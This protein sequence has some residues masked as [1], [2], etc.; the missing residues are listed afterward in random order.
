MSYFNQITSTFAGAN[1]SA[2]GTLETNELSPVF[3]GDFA[4]GINTQLWNYF[5]TFTVTAPAVAPLIGD[6]YTNTNSTFTVIYISGTT[7][8]MQGTGT[9]AASGNLVRVTGI[10]STPIVYSAFTSSA[11]VSVGAGALVDTDTGR[12]RLQSGTSATGF[13]YITSRK[14]LRHRAGQG[15]TARFTPLFTTGVANSTQLWGVGGI[16]S[17]APYDGFYFG[18]NGISYGIVHYIGATPTWYS[19]SVDWNGDKVNGTAGTSFTLDPTKGSAVMI[20]YP[21]LG[22]G[23]VLFFIQNPTDSTWVLVH[24]IRYANTTTTPE[25]TNPS[26]QF[27]CYNANSGAVANKIMY[28]GSVGMFISGVVSL[29]S[30][31]KYAADSTKTTVTTEVC[32]LS[33]RNCSTFNGVINRG[34]IRL[35]S[36]SIG[37]GS[38]TNNNT[39]T[40]RIKIGGTLGGTPSYTPIKGTT[41]DNGATITAGNSITSFDTAATTISGGT[42]IYNMSLGTGAGMIIDL[43]TLGLFI[44]PNEICS[45]TITSQASAT[46][47]VSINW[48]EDI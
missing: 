2:F 5:Y 35:N 9:P 17:N 29:F 1:Q 23:N 25:L 3:Q 46:I 22:F 48:S 21:Y 8:I 13:A 45:I 18:Y 44:N 34:V 24:T 16:I 39:A 40:L 32:A 4:Y 19:Q 47:A 11:G 36:L 41:T 20:K 37:Q 10:G 7:I 26:L 28:A 27:V 33:L 42:Y 30:N 38:T 6:Q 15:T 31:I 43:S 14:V 12:L